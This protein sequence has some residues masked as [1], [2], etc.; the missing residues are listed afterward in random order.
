MTTPTAARR[1]KL[2]DASSQK[3][4]CI[5]CFR[6]TTMNLS[7]HVKNGMRRPERWPPCLLISSNDPARKIDFTPCPTATKSSRRIGILR[8]DFHARFARCSQGK[9]GAGLQGTTKAALA[10]WLW[11]RHR[12]SCRRPYSEH[13][14]YAA[15]KSCRARFDNPR[16]CRQQGRRRRR[17]RRRNSN[18]H[19]NL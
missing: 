3:A 8:G 13:A 17:T 1:E 6:T 5:F 19:L 11:A 18:A 16:S 9:N 12:A 7:V 10:R 2:S 15:G 4:K 14:A